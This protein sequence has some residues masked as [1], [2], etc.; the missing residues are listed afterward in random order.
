MASN[1]VIGRE[2]TLPWH[3]PDDLKSFKRRTLG[4]PI[5]MGRAT[6][7]SLPKRRPLP[8]RRNL[9][10]SRTMPQEPGVEILRTPEALRSL[11]LKGDAYVIGGAAV[12]KRFLPLCH[13]VILTAIHA[14][15][16]GDTWMPPFETHFTFDQTLETYPEFDVKRYRRNAPSPAEE[17]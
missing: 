10:L 8:R 3:L 14:P 9:V 15:Y 1:R 16:P 12:F 13:S 4:H 2:G 7:E 6:F 11:D 5:L 17:A